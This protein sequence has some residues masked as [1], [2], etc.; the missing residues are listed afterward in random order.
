MSATDP[1]G[2]VC[3]SGRLVGL[4]L[5]GACRARVGHGS[6]QVGSESFVLVGLAIVQGAAGPRDGRRCSAGV[7]RVLNA[8]G[9]LA[10]ADP[11][12]TMESPEACGTNL[13]SVSYVAFAPSVEWIAPICMAWSVAQRRSPQRL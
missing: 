4:P 13:S 5:G 2:E 8:M 9:R 7:A 12:F 11:D 1:A 6:G 10:R 3:G